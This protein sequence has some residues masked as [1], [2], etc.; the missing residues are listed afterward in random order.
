MAFQT[1]A[2][3]LN[4]T[5]AVYQPLTIDFKDIHIIIIENIWKY[6]PY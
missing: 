5:Y 3:G 4:Q 2:R 6:Q 1:F